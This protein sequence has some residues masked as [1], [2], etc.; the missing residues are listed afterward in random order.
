MNRIK[1]AVT[2]ILMATVVA[3]AQELHDDALKIGVMSDMNGSL[4]DYDGEGDVIGVKLPQA[5]KSSL[6]SSISR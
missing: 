4:A 6:W 3:D 1:L 5:H 2:A